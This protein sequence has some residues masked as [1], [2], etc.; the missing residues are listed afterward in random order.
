MV[1]PFSFGGQPAI[2]YAMN[3]DGIPVGK[4]TSITMAKLLFFSLWGAAAALFAFGVLAD[5]IRNF[6]IF[7]LILIIASLN[8]AVIILG[9]YSFFHPKLLFLILNGL[10]SLIRL[11]HLQSHFPN[12]RR[13]SAHEAWLSRRIFRHYLF[14]GDWHARLGIAFAFLQELFLSLL[15]FFILRGFGV[16]MM[17]LQGISRS[18]L[19]FFLMWFMPTPG[20]AGIGEGI[21]FVLFT[22][23][24]PMNVLG[25]AAILW[26]FFFQ[27]FKAVIGGFLTFRHFRSLWREETQLPAD[28]ELS[29]HV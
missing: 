18:I 5:Q 7:F 9:F 29:K 12:F 11:F 22:G 3:R 24:A 4:A 10:E 20:G 1:S 2:I 23:I 28:P 13:E 21:F 27:Y 6:F 26:R 17:T 15:M 19:L 25:I 16:E 8:I 14:G